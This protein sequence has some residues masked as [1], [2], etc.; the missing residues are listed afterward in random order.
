MKLFD[1][2]LDKNFQNEF[3][4]K[5]MN[6]Y[7]KWGNE[8]ILSL[9]NYIKSQECNNDIKRLK[10][11]DYFTEIPKKFYIKKS[12]SNRRRIC[13]KFPQRDKFLFKLMA[14]GLMYYDDMYVDSLYSFRK[15]NPHRKFFDI[16]KKID[17]DR[18]YYVL[19]LDI[20]RYGESLDQ[21]ILLDMIKPMLN[22]D[23]DFYNYLKWL[24]TR[25]MYYEKGKLYNNKISIQP[26]IPLGGFMNNV[27]LMDIDNYIE[28]NSILYMRYADDIAIYLKTYEECVKMKNYLLDALSKIHLSVNEEKTN[29]YCPGETYE[30]LGIKISS[31]GCYDIAKNSV[32]KITHKISRRSDKLLKKI[33]AKKID[34]ITAHYILQKYINKYFYGC[35]QKND[36]NWVSWSFKIIT[37]TDTLKYLDNFIQE[38]LR[39]VA[40]GK[41]S[42]ARYRIN[43][44]YLKKYGYISLVHAYYHGYNKDVERYLNLF[45]IKYL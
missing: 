12:R 5:K 9:C 23:I 3:M 16:T 11:G 21:D 36:L 15:N 14:Y 37:T 43:Y 24:F 17:F 41:K 10:N 28:K 8:E 29:I 1:L 4:K 32:N 34:K 38:R 35:F 42:K 6:S 27:Y 44:N 30:I 18:K 13:Y 39:M 25:N 7:K 22:N 33:W 45:D 19:K 20:H 31:N 40:S 2:I 26:G